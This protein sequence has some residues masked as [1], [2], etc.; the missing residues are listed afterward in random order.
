MTDGNRG[1]VKE[2]SM[3]LYGSVES[4]E[5]VRDRLRAGEFPVAVYGLG[6]MGLP[7]AGAF[8]ELTGAVTGV[9]VDPEV[10]STVNDGVSHVQ[11]EPGLPEL[12]RSQVETDRLEATTDGPR[13]ASQSTIH[14]VIVPTLLDE[15]SNPDLSIVES[16]CRDIAKGL[17]AGDLVIAESTLPPGTCRD[18][19]YPT[20]CAESGLEPGAFGLAFCPERTSSGRALRDIRGAYPKVVGGVDDES[21]FAAATIYDELT[22]NEVHV[23]SDTT[24]AEAVKVF[25]GIYRD[26]NIALANELATVADELDVSVRE[27][28]QTANYLPMC[29]IHRPGPGVGGHCIPFYPHFLLSQVDRPLPLTHTARNVN[30][31]MPSY[32]V[33]LLS[34]I[35]EENDVRLEDAA[36]LVLGFTYRSG[37]EEMRASPAIDVVETLHEAGSTV[38]GIDPLVDPSAYGARSL[39]I[40]DL[41]DHTFDAAILVTAHEEFDSIPWN[42]MDPMLVLDGRDALDLGETHHRTYVLGGPTKAGPTI[43]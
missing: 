8:A 11:G 43:Y 38:F 18:V 20:L 31:E 12:V 16:V 41:P 2:M 37:I 42:D 19:L 3:E 32:T 6:K 26:V 17:N 4:P 9:D 39:D 36:V 14:V 35:L 27:A 21:G 34:S 15:A 13:A 23:V 1:G 30:V 5:T 40:D 29:D 7:L 22:S 25:E 33:S 24:T 10:V 28:I